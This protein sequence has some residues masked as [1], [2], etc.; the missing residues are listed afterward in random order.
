MKVTTSSDA[1]YYSLGLDFKEL[2]APP[3]DV[4][5]FLERFQRMLARLVTLPMPTVAAI[6]GHA[7]AGG[8]MF[9]LAHDFTIAS[10]GKGLF[11]LNEIDLGLSFADG[12]AKLMKYAVEPRIFPLLE[13]PT[14]RSLFSVLSPLPGLTDLDFNSLLAQKSTDTN[15]KEMLP[16]WADATLS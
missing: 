3:K 16:S 6:N 4:L 8:A 15:F 14:A 7:T 2:S 5:A 13:R 11:F 9:A 1:K 10:E 12:M